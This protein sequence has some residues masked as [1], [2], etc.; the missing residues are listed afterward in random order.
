[1][2]KIKVLA[3]PQTFLPSPDVRRGC[4]IPGCEPGPGQAWARGTFPALRPRSSVLVRFP[5]R[6]GC[7]LSPGIRRMFPPNFQLPWNNRGDGGVQECGRLCCCQVE[8][9]SRKKRLT[10]TSVLALARVGEASRTNSLEQPQ[11]KTFLIPANTF[12]IFRFLK[13]GAT[14]G[15]GK[16]PSGSFRRRNLV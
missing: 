5:I 3:P 10:Q 2:K 13:T 8:E 15:G 11:L 12:L 7:C 6:A 4:L 9:N 1:M 16:L 14:S